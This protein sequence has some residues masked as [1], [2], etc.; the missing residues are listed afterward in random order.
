MG[1]VSKQVQESFKKSCEKLEIP[2][3]VVEWW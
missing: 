2:I 3:C 1:P